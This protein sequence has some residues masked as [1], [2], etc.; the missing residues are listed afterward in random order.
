MACLTSPICTS[1]F[2][3]CPAGQSRA[4]LE[5]LPNGGALFTRKGR[6]SMFLLSATVPSHACARPVTDDGS[7]RAE[8]SCSC[9]V[10]PNQIAKHSKEKLFLLSHLPSQLSSIS[11]GTSSF[12]FDSH[13]PQSSLHIPLQSF[14][15]TTSDATPQR[16]EVTVGQRSDPD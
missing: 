5:M 7:E 6:P 15:Y 14:K 4:L 2:S 8:L 3:P 16:P 12:A 13:S 11:S 1:C 10:M 9:D